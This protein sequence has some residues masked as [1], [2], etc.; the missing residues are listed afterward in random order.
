MKEITRKIIFF[1]CLITMTGCCV[2]TAAWFVKGQI[3]K[4][5]SR[6]LAEQFHSRTAQTIQS[7]TGA[8]Q[9]E[10]IGKSKME[11]KAE[12]MNSLRNINNDLAGWI[13]IPGT[14]LDYPVVQTADNQFY[15]T[16]NFY[17]EKDK[18]GAVFMDY[19]CGESELQNTILYG[20]HMK[21]GTMFHELSQYKKKEFY[22]NHQKI[23]FY[24]SQGKEHNYQ[25]I[26]VFYWDGEKADDFPFYEYVELTEEAF[27]QY[28]QGVKK[29]A[30]Y[31]I[32]VEVSNVQNLITLATCD[33]VSA[34]AR[35]LVV[36]VEAAK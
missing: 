35:L 12:V 36:G 3:Q 26:S 20:H 9:S 19:R 22:E 16:N 33:Y 8:D 14:A 21:D 6:Q 11:N 5:E 27:Y 28:I 15:M 4:Q 34:D 2:Y 23:T 25:I 17:R 13:T 10:D 7:S 18:H 29:K 1:L 32:P 31:D 24:D 30:I